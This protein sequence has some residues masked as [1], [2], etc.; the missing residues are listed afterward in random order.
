MSKIIAF[1]LPQFHAIP[2]NNKWWGEGF[3]EWSNTKKAEKLYEDHYQPREPLNDYYYNLLEKKD[4]KWQ[5]ETAKKYGVYGFCYYHY[6]FN[7]KLLLE[8]PVEI[9]LKEKHI[10]MPFCFCWANEPWTRAWDGGEKEV[11]M[12]QTYGNKEKW[13][14]HIQYL[15]Q[16]FKDERYIKIDN[17][18]VFVIYRT[19]NI[20]CCEELVSFWNIKC[21]EAGFDG[22]YIIEE[23][24]TFQKN[25]VLENSSAVIEFEPMLTVNSNSN[26]S[27]KIK[28]KLKEQ[29][30]KKAGLNFLDT[31]D[32]DD[33]W[34][35]IINRNS[36][37]KNKKTIHGAFVDWDNTA[38]KKNN[39]TIIKGSSPE[40]FEKYL[41]QQL[42]K[43]NSQKNEFLFINAWNEWAEG[44][45]LEP[46]KKN[47]YEYLEALSRAIKNQKK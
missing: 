6:W 9:L 23:V 5:V 3:T 43:S 37:Y 38:R 22:I 25:P 21:K 1:H 47:G 7:G 16:F 13:L 17:K 8:K 15:I 41:T 45:Y 34:K 19:N 42:N 24:N 33:V 29:L 2:E 11:I 30:R 28:R 35:Q 36:V 18:P 4:I 26:I 46:D 20:N 14:E 27:T 12:S 40:K 39:A 10:N 32:Y 44:T 31:Y